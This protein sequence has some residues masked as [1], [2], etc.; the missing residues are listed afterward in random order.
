MKLSELIERYEK[1]ILSCQCNIKK[2]EK[3]MS[4]DDNEDFSIAMKKG[5]SNNVFSIN[6]LTDIINDLKEV[7]NI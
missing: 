1:E 7:T 4:Q 6:M 5:I 3:R 2:L